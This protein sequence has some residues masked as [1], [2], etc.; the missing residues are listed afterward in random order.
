MAIDIHP[1]NEIESLFSM[2]DMTN[3]VEHTG[4]FK[5]LLLDGSYEPHHVLEESMKREISILCAPGK[6]GKKKQRNLRKQ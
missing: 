3:K 6:Q 5:E 2:L 4:A 1:S